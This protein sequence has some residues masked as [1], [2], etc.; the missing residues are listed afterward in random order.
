LP[1]WFQIKVRSSSS[2]RQVCTQRSMIEFILGIRMLVVTTRTPASWN[3]A[4][5]APVFGY[6][7]LRDR[8]PAARTAH[9]GADRPVHTPGVFAE[10]FSGAYLG[11]G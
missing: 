3:A 10:V 2:R 7:P 8:A 6:D 1:R 11:Y 9:H 4:S 5:N